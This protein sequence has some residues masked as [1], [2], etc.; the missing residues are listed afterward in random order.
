ME[1]LARERSE[2]DA[3]RRGEE[4]AAAGVE[5]DSEDADE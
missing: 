3:K 5:A 1:R 2:R 4:L